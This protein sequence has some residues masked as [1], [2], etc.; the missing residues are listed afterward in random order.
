MQS[1]TTLKNRINTFSVLILFFVFQVN[2]F[3][4]TNKKI[5]KAVQT[6][7]SGKLEKGIATMTKITDKEPSDKNWDILVQMQF[8]RYKYAVEVY[9]NNQS[10]QLVSVIGNSL[11]ASM[12]SKDVKYASPSVCFNDL[13]KTCKDAGLYSQSLTASMYLRTF[14]VDYQPDSVISKE[15][16]NVFNEAEAFF[17]KKDYKNSK[18]YYEKALSIQP[19]FYKAIIYLGDSYWYLNNMDSAI[20]YFQKGIDMCPDL[21]EPRKY[22]VDALTY[23][24][25]Y[26][27]GKEECINTIFIY[28]DQSM[29]DKYADLL[30]KT[31]LVFNKH[32]V[33]R[34]CEINV[35]GNEQEKTT[36]AIWKHYQAAKNEIVA[37][38]DKNGLIQSN[39]L[40][41]SRYLEVYSWEKML[42]STTNLPEELKFAKKMADLG[43][44]DCYV[45]ISTFHFDLYSQYI[46]FVQHNKD[47]IKTYIE[48][49]LVD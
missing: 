48:T 8:Y 35:V 39:N 45:F 47:R 27:E 41:T 38:C 31:G 49:Y 16:K 44:L 17:S 43:Y 5:E 7:N 37:N 13:V 14:F 20:H 15:A 21:V 3:G 1:I 28:P 23:S 29:F 2:L 9:E 36:D 33:K 26:D 11:G 32:W 4:Q 40:T 46:D 18:L 19:N 30:N 6:F 42:N 22:M 10:N 34:A 12:K 24:K 25:R